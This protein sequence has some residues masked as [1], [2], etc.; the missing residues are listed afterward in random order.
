MFIDLKFHWN[1]QMIFVYSEPDS[2][3][4]ISDSEKSF[5]ENNIVKKTTKP[6][7][8]KPF[9]SSIPLWAIIIAAVRNIKFIVFQKYQIFS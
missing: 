8:W 6:I 1:F 5:L 4:F 3:P 9:L 2:H 7:P